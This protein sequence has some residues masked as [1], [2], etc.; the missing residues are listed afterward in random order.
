MSGRKV[1]EAEFLAR[2]RFLASCGKF[3]VVTPPAV[4]LLLSSAHQNFAVA[5]SGGLHRHR[6]NWR[7]SLRRHHHKHHHGNNGF[8]N[9]G[10]D[11]VPGHSEKSDLTR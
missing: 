9:G 5:S 1:S 8:G 4:T 6:H 11:G 3:A 7:H 2:R 10:R